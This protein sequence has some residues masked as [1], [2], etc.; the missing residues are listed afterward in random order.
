MYVCIWIF[1]FSH[2]QYKFQNKACWAWRCYW[3]QPNQ[4]PD[5]SKPQPVGARCVRIYSSSH[6]QNWWWIPVNFMRRRFCWV[7][8]WRRR[9]SFLVAQNSQN[10]FAWPQALF[11]YFLHSHS[12]Y[13]SFFAGI[14]SARGAQSQRFPLIISNYVLEKLKAKGWMVT[15]PADTKRSHKKSWLVRC[16]DDLFSRNCFW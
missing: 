4:T 10:F 12:S 7:N 2:L 13:C 1:K 3:D 15:R 16:S 9:G 8:D 11:V 6:P 14:L 5:R